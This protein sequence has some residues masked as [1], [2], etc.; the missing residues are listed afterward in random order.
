MWSDALPPCDAGVRD[1]D[2]PQNTT[3][4]SLV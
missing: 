1:C 2:E 3:L 4:G